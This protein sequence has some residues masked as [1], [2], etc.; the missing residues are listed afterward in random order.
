MTTKATA[1][2]LPNL[3]GVEGTIYFETVTLPDLTK[4]TKIYGSISG[5]APGLHGLHIH[6]YGTH[7][8]KD[9]KNCCDIFGGHYNPFNKDHGYPIDENRH[10]GDLGNIHANR[11]GY[12]EI[13]L[14]D[15]LIQLSGRYSVLNRS[16]IVH[17]N[18]DDGGME[19]TIE[20]KT[21][22]TSGPRLACALIL[23]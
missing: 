3:N 17:A 16:L 15:P 23:N 7:V 22:G 18:T 4:G 9:Y 2:F 21:T 13:R 19:D 8:V 12:A 11:N 6:T 5:L 20:S 10:V 14:I 1:T